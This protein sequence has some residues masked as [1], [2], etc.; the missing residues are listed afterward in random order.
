MSIRR[1]VTYDDGV[2]FAGGSEEY[3]KWPKIKK[4]KIMSPKDFGRALAKAT[5]VDQMVKAGKALA[6]CKPRDAKCIAKNLGNVVLN[7]PGM[8]LSGGT[9]LVGNARAIAKCKPRDSKCIA[10]QLGDAALT[11]SGMIPGVGA[12]GRA[13]RV[14]KMAAMAAKAAKA[15][16][17]VKGSAAVAGTFM[18]ENSG[19]IGGGAA[20]LGA[21]A[22]GAMALRGGGEPMMGPDGEP[23]VGPDGQPM[24][25]APPGSP[26]LPGMPGTPGFPGAPGIPGY[27]GIPGAPGA[28]TVITPPP[29][30][31]NIQISGKD[32]AA[33]SGA[34]QDEK[35]GK[36][37]PPGR[38]S[39]TSP[40]DTKGAD[41]TTEEDGGGAAKSSLLDTAKSAL[42]GAAKKKMTGGSDEFT[43]QGA[44][45]E[46]S[47]SIN[48]FAAV[49]F[50]M[51]VLVIFFTSQ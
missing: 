19:A 10:E 3:I 47:K 46:S 49:F 40:K 51:C 1:R 27:P 2:F 37:Q 12:A 15:A 35:I 44:P 29:I 16:K 34:F 4:P 39:I 18:G 42:F 26:G 36:Q 13:A 48:W 41:A 8:K 38:A 9:D 22:L 25:T 11:A 28:S 17:A 30:K 33:S 7:S 31:I 20:L 24:L 6:K 43:I 21:G 45:I 23:V 14:A 50:L 5:G 32:M